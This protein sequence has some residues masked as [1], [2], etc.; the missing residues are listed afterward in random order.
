[1]PLPTFPDTDNVPS[2]VT[3]GPWGSAIT[4]PGDHRKL[5][6]SSYV[7]VGGDNAVRVN[8]VITY[9]ATGVSS[10]DLITN[11]KWADIKTKINSEKTRRTGSGAALTLSTPINYTDFNN[12]RAALNVAGPG[13][14]AAYNTDGTIDISNYPQLSAPAVP[15][16]VAS[17]TTIGYAELSSLVTALNS[18]APCTCNC[19]Y[20]GCNCNYCTC[21]CNYTCTC[22]CNYSDERLKENIEFV[23]TEQGINL[24]SWTY[25]WDKATTYVGVIAQEILGTVYAS[26]ISTDINGYYM[27][28]YS[29]LPVSMT[30]G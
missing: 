8:G 23:G 12:M 11:A 5:L 28:D 10:G 25:L 17:G 13:P 4:P 16:A 15:A 30:R 19:N 18:A 14:D 20:C 27:V 21:N 2:G 29:K 24:Y 7:G 26:A 3:G 1:M 22:N 6:V 9:G